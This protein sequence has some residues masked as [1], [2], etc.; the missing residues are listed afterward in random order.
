MFLFGQFNELNRN[1]IQSNRLHHSNTSASKNKR[2][3]KIR[4]YIV[5]SITEYTNSLMKFHNAQTFT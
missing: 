5:A 3:V 4:N 2:E 1:L